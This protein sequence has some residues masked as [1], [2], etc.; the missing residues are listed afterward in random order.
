MLLLYFC[1]LVNHVNKPII[2]VFGAFAYHF[3]NAALSIINLIRLIRDIQELI[4][5][6]GILNK[7]FQ[8][9][10]TVNKKY[11]NIL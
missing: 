6:I 9:L 11:H 7:D 1:L 3:K 8:K 2:F 4:K 5:F 10:H